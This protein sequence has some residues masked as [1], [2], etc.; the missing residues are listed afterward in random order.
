MMDDWVACGLLPPPY[1]FAVE[2]EES[3]ERAPGR[4]HE[5]VERCLQTRDAEACLHAD[6]WL[7]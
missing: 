4:G 7:W 3:L 2:G 1:S 6:G 5:I